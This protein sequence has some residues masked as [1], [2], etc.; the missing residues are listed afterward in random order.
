MDG[1]C[2]RLATAEDAPAI[3]EIYAPYVTR[4]AVTFETVP[5]DAR[6]FRRRVES[7]LADYPFLVAEREGVI[8]GYAYAAAFGDRAAYIWAAKES[9]YVRAEARHEG[10]GRAL[11]EALEGYLKRQDVYS[12][13]ACITLSNAGS[14]EFHRSLGFAE[15]GRF[16]KCAYKLGAWEDVIWMEKVLIPSD[17][18]PRP[19]IPFR[20]L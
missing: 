12:V 11:Y 16:T 13:S 18:V 9:V 7:T 4:T 8:L 15:A 1:F 20:E 14:V 5:P 19:F 6:E 17:D 2:V 10:V 3:A